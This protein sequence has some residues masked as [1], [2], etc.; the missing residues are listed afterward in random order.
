M[1]I[2]VCET[3]LLPRKTKLQR[4]CKVDGII[5]GLLA[6]GY[7]SLGGDSFSS[8]EWKSGR[9]V[10]SIFTI[11]QVITHW[12]GTPPGGWFFN[13][14]FLHWTWKKNFDIS[15]SHQHNEI[16]HSKRQILNEPWPLCHPEEGCLRHS[17]I[18]PQI[19]YAS[20]IWTRGR[21][22]Y[23]RALPNTLDVWEVVHRYSRWGFQ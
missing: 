4:R 8:D 1:A 20:S 6:K 5:R 22:V 23:P 17:E 19:D 7:N 16:F 11:F 12:S 13:L 14:L 9:Q 10:W 2:W 18:S 21:C 3:V 15:I